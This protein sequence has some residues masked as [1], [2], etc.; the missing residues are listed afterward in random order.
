MLKDIFSQKS[1]INK[2]KNCIEQIN[3]LENNFKKLNDTELRAKT[4]ELKN[5][6]KLNKI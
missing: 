3:S 2:Y 4:F 6:I 5:N 1:V